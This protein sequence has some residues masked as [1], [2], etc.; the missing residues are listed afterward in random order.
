MDCF[1]PPLLP[2]KGR[3]SNP[4]ATSRCG[5]LLPSASLLTHALLMTTL[6]S[7]G[8]T[9]Q[10]HNAFHGQ[11][12]QLPFPGKVAKHK[13]VASL[14]QFAGASFYHLVMEVL[15]RL[16]LL[17]PRLAADPTLKVLV[18]KDSKSNGFASQFYQLVVGAV[19]KFGHR[20]LDSRRHFFPCLCWG[21][22]T[23][24]VI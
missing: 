5:S 23:M 3:R 1:A 16:L 20:N 24:R 19:L 4:P 21:D 7:A 14:L 17:R 9:Y 15:P 2:S 13:K 12:G 18:C 6:H 8:P 10:W 22:D 11:F